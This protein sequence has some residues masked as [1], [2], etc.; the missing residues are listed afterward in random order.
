MEAIDTLVPTVGVVAACAALAFARATYYRRKRPGSPTKPRPRPT[1]ALGDDER[2][3]VLD[4][5]NSERFADKAPAQVYAELLTEGR[6]LCSI[7]TMYRILEANA[8][9]RE[10]RDV[11]RHPSYTKPELVATGPNQVWSWDITKL[12]GP[13]KWSY[14]YLYV[15]LD[16][17]SRYVVGWMVATR[18]TAALGQQLIAEC[19]E[20]QRVSPGQLIVHA[21][22]GSPMTAKST[23]LLMADLGVTK[24]HSRPH[25]SDDNP[26][27]EAQFKTVKYRPDLPDRFG[28]AQDARMHIS[29]LMRWYNHEHHHSGLALLTPYQVHH[30]LAHQITRRRQVALD[31]VYALRPE[32]FPNGAPQAAMPPAEV[33]INPPPTNTFSSREILAH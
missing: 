28:C 5:L 27:S 17:F 20:R 1:R 6:Y 22:R 21:D 10:R 4:T 23:A 3:L 30:G 33:W 32:R 25:V 24:S 18:E 31:H 15:V 13:Q 19:C 26:Y 14:F 11:R 2:K 12:H 16:I 7:R 9:V 8:L 29:P